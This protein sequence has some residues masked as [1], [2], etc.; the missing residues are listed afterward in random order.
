MMNNL[1][2]L[3]VD[4]KTACYLL[5][6][7]RTSLFLALKNGLLVRKKAGRKSLVTMESIR[8]FADRGDA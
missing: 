2:P 7:K 3:L 8:A 5:G 4:T 1:E 6:I